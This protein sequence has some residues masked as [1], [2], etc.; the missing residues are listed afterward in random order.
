MTGNYGSSTTPT[1]SRAS[2][3]I[4]VVIFGTAYL[5]ACRAIGHFLPLRPIPSAPDIWVREYTIWAVIFFIGAASEWVGYFVISAHDRPNL[6]SPLRPCRI[7]LRAAATLALLIGG[8]DSTISVAF[9]HSVSHGPTETGYDWSFRWHMALGVLA[10]PCWL[11]R[12]WL[13]RSLLVRR[14]AI[15]YSSSLGIMLL[16]TA[17][18]G[19][20]LYACWLIIAGSALLVDLARRYYP[21]GLNWHDPIA[22]L[23][24]RDSWLLQTGLS[25]GLILCLIACLRLA[26]GSHDSVPHAVDGR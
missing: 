8:A 17:L 22:S 16:A 5:L 21:A 1:V 3:G 13:L 7:G 11:A 10:A 25:L 19:T 18:L 24:R 6:G 20:L 4:S 15:A 9:L 23:F 12:L 14:Y 2:L 26:K